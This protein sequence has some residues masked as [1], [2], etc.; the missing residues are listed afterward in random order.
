[1]HSFKALAIGLAVVAPS[2]ARSTS[3]PYTDLE[4]R[5]SSTSSGNPLLNWLG[6]LIR[7]QDGQSCVEDE[8]FNFAYNSTFGKDFCMA[9]MSYPNT[10]VT[11]DYTP[12]AR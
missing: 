7:R 10:T 2:S 1:M 12:A 9:F 8:Y 11:S 6:R 3:G 4:N 5:D